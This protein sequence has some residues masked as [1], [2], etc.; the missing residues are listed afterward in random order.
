MESYGKKNGLTVFLFKALIAASCRTDPYRLLENMQGLSY[1]Y[2]WLRPVTLDLLLLNFEARTDLKIKC[3]G[4]LSSSFECA[5]YREL[6]ICVG[7][8]GRAGLLF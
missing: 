4:M 1:N 7:K 2:T 8:L 5:I 6:C 3:F